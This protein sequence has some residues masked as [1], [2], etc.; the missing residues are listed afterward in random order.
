[1][2]CGMRLLWMECDW[3]LFQELNTWAVFW[4][5]QV[6]TLLSIIGRWRIEG[7]L[8]MLSDPWLY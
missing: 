5:N 8:L 2:D 7:K 6:Q 4:M 1:M 3:R